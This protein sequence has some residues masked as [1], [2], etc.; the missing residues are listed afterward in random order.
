MSRTFCSVV[1]WGTGIR[2]LL[3]RMVGSGRR[4]DL[5]KTDVGKLHAVS[6]MWH[7]RFICAACRLCCKSSVCEICL[8]LDE[9][10]TVFPVLGIFSKD[11]GN[12]MSDL[13][14]MKFAE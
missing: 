4:P 14:F 6:C 2:E 12:L 3:I 11:L 13:V 10:T 9:T 7:T 8:T 5:R 1:G